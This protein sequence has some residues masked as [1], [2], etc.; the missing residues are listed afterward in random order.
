MVEMEERIAPG[1]L[2]ALTGWRGRMG[3]RSGLNIRMGTPPAMEAPPREVTAMEAPSTYL[4]VSLAGH[5]EGRAEMA[6]GARGGEGVWPGPGAG[7][8]VVRAPGRGRG[9]IASGTSPQACHTRSPH[10][11]ASGGEG[12]GVRRETEPGLAKTL[13][14]LVS[15]K[16]AY[17]YEMGLCK[18]S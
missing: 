9:A 1:S 15:R 11:D 10:Y 5:R 18:P 7:P 17:P 12:S 8:K 4:H 14:P 16:P 13:P 3:S 2:V 6:D